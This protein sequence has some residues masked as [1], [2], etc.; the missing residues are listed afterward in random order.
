MP[1]ITAFL[2]NYEPGPERAYAL[3]GMELMLGLMYVILG[4]TGIA[5]KLIDIC[6][7]SLKAGI[8][9][10]S[11]FAACAGPYGFKS[12]ADGGKGFFMYPI[13]WS[14]GCTLGI[15]LLFV[16]AI[17]V[18]GVVGMI[19]GECALPDFSGVTSFWFNPIPGLTWVWKNFSILGVGIPPLEILAKDLPMAIMCYVI[20]FGDIVG[21]TAFLQDTKRYR[22]DEYIDISPDR[23]NMCCGFRNL[24]EAFFSPTCTMSG[25]L[26]SAMTVSVAERY[27]T[28]KENMYS[29]FGG[30]CSFNTTK[31]ICQLIV[32]LMALIRPILPLAMAQTL[33]IQAFGSFYVGMNMARTNVERGVAGITAGAIAICPN[34]SYGLFVGIVLCIFIEVINMNREDRRANVEEG[35]EIYVKNTQDDLA[36]IRAKDAAH[37]AKKLA[38]A[39]R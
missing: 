38:K 20:A 12:L 11:G 30:S 34:P 23:T 36:E 15:F 2:L 33:I 3:V 5:N 29:I 28:G 1:L 8:L 21:G 16:P 37:D 22:Q 24:I 9:I 6:P 19:T 25:P 31:W 27:K 39:S 7:L 17:I 18:A 35:V 10:G 4:A 13:A 32:P 26:W 14:I